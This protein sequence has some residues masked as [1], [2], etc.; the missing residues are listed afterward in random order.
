MMMKVFKIVPDK[1]NKITSFIKRN[2]AQNWVNKSNN[3]LLSFSASL[4][5]LAKGAEVVSSVIRRSS[6]SVVSCELVLY[7][8]SVRYR[9]PHLRL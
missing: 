2:C 1:V 6:G 9:S 5:M 8:R 3:Y 7:F 4:T